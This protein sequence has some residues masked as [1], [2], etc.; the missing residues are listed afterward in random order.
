VV[1]LTTAGLHTPVKPSFEKP[2]KAGTVPPE[3]IVSDVP[4]LNEAVMLG[5]TSTCTVV[6]TAH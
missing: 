6:V 1:L 2:G 3:Q 5:I 4:K